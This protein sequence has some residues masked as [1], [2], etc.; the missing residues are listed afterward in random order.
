MFQFYRQAEKKGGRRNKERDTYEAKTEESLNTH[1]AE[2]PNANIERF[3][4]STVVESFKSMQ[5]FKAPQ[6]KM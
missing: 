3:F 1:R 6:S 5:N 2:L 4:T